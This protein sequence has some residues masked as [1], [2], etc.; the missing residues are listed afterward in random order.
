VNN[1]FAPKGYG[2]F[3]NLGFLTWEVTPPKKKKK[4]FLGLVLV[5]ITLPQI[6]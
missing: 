3:E 4:Y 6:L 5:A 1:H 2:Q